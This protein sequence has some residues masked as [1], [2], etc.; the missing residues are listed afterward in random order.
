MKY[1]EMKMTISLDQN[2]DIKALEM[3]QSIMRLN[4]IAMRGIGNKGYKYFT[5]G[6]IVPVGN[7]KTKNCEAWQFHNVTA[8]DADTIVAAQIWL[9]EVKK[10]L[11]K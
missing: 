1:D 5:F 4:Q 9:D 3:F 11:L 6:I 2:S 7:A 10:D 8:M